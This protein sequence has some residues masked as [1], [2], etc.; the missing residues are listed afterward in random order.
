MSMGR[1]FGSLNDQ[2]AL[3]FPVAIHSKEEMAKLAEEMKAFA[4]ANPFDYT[5]KKEEAA[6]NPEIELDKVGSTYRARGH[7]PKFMEPWQRMITLDDGQTPPFQVTYTEGP[8]RDVEGIIQS[9]N[10]VAYQR[11]SLPEGTVG[12]FASCFWDLKNKD[13]LAEIGVVDE[14]P[15]HVATLIRNVK[16]GTNNG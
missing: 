2:F 10:I 13:V 6:N 16:P 15:P 14:L 8:M 9:L 11:L 3:F 1:R 4:K 7:D 12:F 5:Q